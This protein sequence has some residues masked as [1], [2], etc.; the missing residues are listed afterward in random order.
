M[1]ELNSTK[2]IV[3]KVVNQLQVL[4]GITEIYCMPHYCLS[5]KIYEESAELFHSV[6]QQGRFYI[7]KIIIFAIFIVVSK[8]KLYVLIQL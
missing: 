2:K 6:Q 3:F 8:Q 7:K 4:F 1:Q 5:C